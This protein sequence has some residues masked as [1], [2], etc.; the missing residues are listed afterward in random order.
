MKNG[1]CE[2][3][4]GKSTGAKTPEGQARAKTASLVH[5][6]RSAAAMAKRRAWRALNRELDARLESLR[7]GEGLAESLARM[8]DAAAAVLALYADE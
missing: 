8:P 6:E 7:T 3:H 1:K 5:G 2:L 4:G